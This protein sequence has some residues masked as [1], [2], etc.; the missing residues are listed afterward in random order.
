MVFIEDIISLTDRLQDASCEEMGKHIAEALQGREFV[1]EAPYPTDFYEG[2]DEV[3]MRSVYV[4]HNGELCG[5]DDFGFVCEYDKFI[6]RYDMY[7]AIYEK[8][9]EK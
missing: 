8:V 2:G 4:E 9:F 3:Q 5:V 6:H 7:K 1:F